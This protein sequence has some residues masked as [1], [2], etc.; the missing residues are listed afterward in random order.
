MALHFKVLAN[1]LVSLNAGVHRGPK[2]RTMALLQHADRIQR[3]SADWCQHRIR[4][5][6][7]SNY[8]D[9][10]CLPACRICLLCRLLQRLD[11]SRDAE[12][13]HY[14]WLLHV[15]TCG[16]STRLGLVFT[17]HQGTGDRL[18][19]F[20]SATHDGCDNLGTN[21]DR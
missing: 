15:P 10:E 14:C 12:C 11:F 17:Y 2:S 1:V 13:I 16:A 7:Q 4:R 5:S 20:I 18:G 21:R 9:R 8:S 19:R 6:H 3:L